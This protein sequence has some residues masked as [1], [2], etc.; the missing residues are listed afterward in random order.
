MATKTDFTETEWEALRDAP[1]LVA[2]SV[3]IAGGSGIFGSLKEAMA[4]AMALVEAAKGDNA[5]LRD[6][7]QPDEMKASQSALRGKLKFTDIESLRSEFRIAALQ[8]SKSALDLL[9][10]K[11]F[12]DDAAT[13]R[14][15]LWNIGNRVAQA[16]KEGGFLG[17]GGERV[18][19]NERALLADLSGVLETAQS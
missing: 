12:S 10:E 7:C 3:A 11:G 17:F 15:F 18:S 5:L 14:N 1:H 9:N 4:P 19:E 8:V 2:L 6:I 16:A 13:F